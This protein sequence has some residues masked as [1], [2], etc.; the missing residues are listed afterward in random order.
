MRSDSSKLLLIQDQLANKTKVWLLFLFFGWSYGSLGKIGIQILFYITF[1]GFGFWTLIRLFT[2]NGAIKKYN[3]NIC[4][5]VGLS[6]NEML[7]L[8]VI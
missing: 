6:A 1:G 5:R 7:I 2:L 8:G 4:L 3:K